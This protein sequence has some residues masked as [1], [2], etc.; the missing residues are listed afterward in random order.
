MARYH[1]EKW[2]LKAT[3]VFVREWT[4]ARDGDPMKGSSSMG[5]EVSKIEGIE[6]VSSGTSTRKAKSK[7]YIYPDNKI[8]RSNQ[9]VY[10]TSATTYVGHT[11][12]VYEL[13]WG[14]GWLVEHIVADESEYPLDGVQGDYWYI[15]TEEASSARHEFNVY[16]AQW[17]YS[18]FTVAGTF[19]LNETYTRINLD[20]TITLDLQPSELAVG[21]L[22]FHSGWN[23][24]WGTEEV[25]VVKV[26]EVGTTGDG[27]GY[28]KL[29]KE[30]IMLA[31]TK[32]DFIEKIV[33]NGDEYPFN[34]MQGNRWYVRGAVAF[35]DISIGGVQIGGME[36]ITNAGVEEIASIHLIQADGTIIDF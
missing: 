33:A 11:G 9:K 28:G 24:K 12:Q 10:V 14:K 2:S 16:Q 3:E 6:Y 20:G 26:T 7:S 34:G 30:T 35:P 19:I 18:K 4:S 29:S 31:R 23:S 27:E 32:G 21:D 13:Q 15:R 22:V 1:Y 5:Y 8:T 25:F 17:D 36:I